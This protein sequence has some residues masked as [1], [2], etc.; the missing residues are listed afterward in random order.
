MTN[1]LLKEKKRRSKI[2]YTIILGI[3]GAI[4]LMCGDASE[5]L[6]LIGFAAFLG[7]VVI[8]QAED[9]K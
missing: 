2:K 1:T 8:W 4:G 6:G 3:I 5:M 9:K 7:I